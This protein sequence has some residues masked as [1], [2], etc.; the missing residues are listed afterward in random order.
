MSLS[1]RELIIDSIKHMNVEMLSEL[2]NEKYTY[3][4]VKKDIFLL[5]LEDIFDRQRMLGDTLLIPFKG[6]CYS[7]VCE[8][9]GCSG[10]SFIGNK[11]KAHLDLIMMEEG[12][13]FNDIYCCAQF[14]TEQEDVKTGELIIIPIEPDEKPDFKQDV[15]YLISKQKCEN[16]ISEI[17]LPGKI[18]TLEEIKYWL[19]KHNETYMLIKPNFSYRAYVRFGEIYENLGY[20]FEITD[21]A[22]AIKLA[23][24][25]LD[26]I[27]LDDDDEM[28]KWFCEHEELRDIFYSEFLND[29]NINHSNSGYLEY[30]GIKVSAKEFGSYYRI[31]NT[32]DPRY[33]FIL[34]KYDTCTVEEKDKLR[35]EYGHINQEYYTITYHLKR[36]GLM[37]RFFNI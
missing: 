24:D 20:L 3:Q 30:K 28:T 35:N 26:T 7:E 17:D 37:D 23:L 2:L 16:A 25:K 11:S 27:N 12:D 15:D 13:D 9:Q 18:L 31:K 19:A 1:K 14:G 36:L 22:H 10:V 34:G 21:K 29:K 33:F 4:E 5:K 6:L 32:F 8:N